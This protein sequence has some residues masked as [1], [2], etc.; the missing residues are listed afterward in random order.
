MKAPIQSPADIDGLQFNDDGL[1]PVIAQDEASGAVLMLAWANADALRQSL[2]TGRMTYWSRS[3]GEIWEKGAT[4]GNTQRLIALCADCDSDA[5][6]AVVEQSG[7][8]CHEGTGTCWT[9]RDEAPVATSLGL[10]DRLAADR[11]RAPEGRYTDSLLADAALV[12]SKVEEEAGEVGA[13]LRGEDNEDTLEHEAADLL[14]HLAVALR[15]A[16]SSLDAAL[17]ELRRRHA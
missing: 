3:R 12:A 7:P 16:G 13:V 11:K 1:I 9:H 6:L 17:R 15:G 14:Y 10:I 8:S 5:V 4:S 2:A